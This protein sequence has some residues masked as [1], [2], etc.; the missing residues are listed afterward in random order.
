MK[1][2]SFIQL[3]IVTLLA[4]TVLHTTNASAKMYM[5][6]ITLEVGEE[7]IVSA[8]PTSGFTASGSF[9][10]D[11]T[12]FVITANG[13]YY[14]TIKANK[15][16][17]GTLSYW[18]SVVPSNS[19]STYI[20]DY[21]WDIEVKGPQVCVTSIT[22]NTS[23]ASLKVGETKQ[24][25]ATVSPSNATDKSVSWSSSNSSVAS[26][27]SSGL[28]TAKG[29]GTATITCRANDGSGVQAT[30]NVTVLEPVTIS[31]N[32][33]NFPDGNFRNYLLEQDYG[34]DGKLTGGEIKDITYIWVNAK[35]ISSLKGIE[36]F[37]ALTSIQCNGNQ[38]TTLDISMNTALTS[39][40]CFDN[41]L[42]ALDVSKNTALTELWCMGNQL[43]ALDV[44]KNTALTSLDCS[45]NQLT[46]LDVSRNTALTS[47]N[48][49]FNQLTA[50]DVSKNT[51]LTELEC[52]ENNIQG[53]EMT[54]LINSLPKNNSNEEHYFRVISTITYDTNICT[55]SQVAAVKAKGWIPQS[56]NLGW[57]WEEYEGS[58]DTSIIINSTNFPDDNFRNYLLEQ[59]YGKDGVLTE[60]EIS[61][62]K[63]ID[64]HE[65]NIS[66]LKG[67]EY[68]TSLKTLYCTNNLLT[69]LDV[70]KNTALTM[71]LCSCNQLTVLDVS[72]NIALTSL[73]CGIN[74][75]T[76]L[77]VSKNTAL[78]SLRCNDNQ[79]TLL[80]VSKNIAL[81]NLNCAF[82]QLTVLDVSKNTA[83]TDLA[84][85]YNQLTA[86]NVSTNTAL[87][88]LYCGNNQLTDLNVSKNTSLVIL[89]CGYNQMTALDISKNKLL[90]CLE[91][92]N[93]KIKGTEMDKL[94]SI[95]PQNPA[96][97]IHYFY[98]IDPT[99][100]NEGNVCTK[101]QVAAVKAKGWTPLYNNG[102]EWVEYEG[103]DDTS[104]A[105]KISLPV[106]QT[107][108]VGSTLQ[109]TPT[110]EPATAEA[111]LTW[112]TD[113]ASIAKV[114][115]TGVVFGS[116]E[117]TAIITVTTDNGLKAECFVM[118]Q[119][120]SG[121]SSVGAD[122][123]DV[124]VYTLSGQR[125][126][127]PQKGI[128]IVGGK[129]VIIR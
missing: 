45:D 4:M 111:T 99:S 116:K 55:K 33:T 25:T 129:K 107:V 74:Q 24:L 22:L 94:I 66:S 76:V 90:Y 104:I 14:C 123:E 120:S 105:T 42:T 86:L 20:Y 9:S 50:L 112:T 30:C 91:C 115:S 121:I 127:A 68:F 56:Y 51:A 35:N 31:I 126:A 77:D 44:S 32:S 6:K 113:D 26:V 114:T 125:L 83:L 95:L 89:T 128:N 58:E 28:V 16:G 92:Q 88:Y 75:L 103:S 52:R 61:K 67:I 96:S 93:N 124:P 21:Y 109:L 38:L 49:S 37:T 98:V 39:L 87:T 102:T 23:S 100:E 110:I 79:L 81:T 119:L 11:G 71:L 41:K 13:S 8:V 40:D 29:A 46:A 34:K 15:A 2:L 70:S 5:G 12:C 118:V 19:W 27:N 36:L 53:K 60:D 7:Y 101:T 108:N 69:A 65:K 47:L 43:K 73:S 80:D 106:S 97:S 63:S 122:S 54:A 62:I 57:K 72:K 17:K 10:K 85:S 18:G 84:C 1:Q 3:A 59:S 117:G 48:C 78:T 64:V 82:N